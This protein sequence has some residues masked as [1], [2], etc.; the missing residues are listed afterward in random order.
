MGTMSGEVI[1]S[2]VDTLDTLELIAR[3]L[4]SGAVTQLSDV[5]VLFLGEKLDNNTSGRDN[6]P[7][8][9]SI[10]ESFNSAEQQNNMFTTVGIAI[11]AG[12]TLTLFGVIFVFVQRRR[13][14]VRA[15]DA[16]QSLED[17]GKS[18]DDVQHDAKGSRDLDGDIAMNE[19]EEVI[20]PNDLTLND[21]HDT[22]CGGY[23]FDLG[24]WMKSELIGIHGEN[25][26]TASPSKG[27]QLESDSD[28]DSWAQTEATLGSLELRLDPIEAEV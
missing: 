24:G 12:L 1:G 19:N 18:V 26:I 11:L 23:Q 25:A 9:I 20:L 10:P 4:S 13:H 28:N 3:H 15:L 6:L 16:H 21:P 5:T 22:C 7:P 8:A 27:E 2:D 14:A 17:D